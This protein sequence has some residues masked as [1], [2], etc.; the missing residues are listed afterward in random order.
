[1]VVVVVVVVAVVVVVVVVAG[2]VVVV[3]GGGLIGRSFNMKVGFGVII[4][5]Q[6]PFFVSMDLN[7]FTRSL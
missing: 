5:S 6:N 7:G 2:V 1:M 3:V 4:S